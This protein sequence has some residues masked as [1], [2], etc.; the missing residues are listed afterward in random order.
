MEDEMTVWY[1]EDPIVQIDQRTLA[2]LRAEVLESPRGLARICLHGKNTD[3]PIQEMVIAYRQGFY[4]PPHK[5]IGKTE[6]FH[7]I[8]GIMA[9]HIFDDGGKLSQAIHLEPFGH[10]RTQGKLSTFLYRFKGEPW[11][12][13][14]PLSDIVILHECTTGPFVPDSIIYPDWGPDPNDQEAIIHFYHGA[15][16]E[17]A[18]R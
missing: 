17:R 3:D 9:V 7:I 8:E 11:H 1:A 18:S 4:Y 5:H 16:M 14:I 13:C 10:P 15:M 2:A 12:G 6:S